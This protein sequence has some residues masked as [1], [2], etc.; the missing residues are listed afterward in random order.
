MST[1]KATQR[2]QELAK[3]S[4]EKMLQ[5]G[6]ALLSECL[7]SP[8]EQLRASE[9]SGKAGLTPGAF[10]HHWA[11]QDEYR[12][13]LRDYVGGVRETNDAFRKASGMSERLLQGLVEAVRLTA[14]DHLASLNADEHWRVSLA[15]FASGNPEDV[16][17]VGAQYM[18]FRNEFSTYFAEVFDFFGITLRP[19]LTYEWLASSLSVIME[20]YGLHYE[21]GVPP[22]E[23]GDGWTDFDVTVAA[24]FTGAILP[25]GE[26]DGDDIRQALEQRILPEDQRTGKPLTP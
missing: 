15:M 19:G 10:Y 17:R 13:E 6:L 20:G 26:T 8:F 12:N 2:K 11:N 7:E 3:V 4:R 5:A 9:V 16:A 14:R 18:D 1:I 25:Y 24:I 21:S 23:L 22:L